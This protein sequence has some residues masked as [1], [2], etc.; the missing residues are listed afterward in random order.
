MPCPAV[1]SPAAAPQCARPGCARP[2]RVR[3]MCRSHYNSTRTKRIRAGDWAPRVSSV[4]ISR[5]LQALM[6]L[7]WP[8]AELG[9]RLGLP[10]SWLSR[11]TTGHRPSVNPATAERVIALY[12]QLSMTPGPSPSARRHATGKGWAPPLAWDDD[13][14]DDP[15]GRA[16]RGRWASVPFVERYRELRDLGLTDLQICQR[17]KVQPGSL[18]RQLHRYGLPVGA[19]LSRAVVT[20]KAARR[21]ARQASA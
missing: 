11:L 6:A 20:D 17:L 12:E 13:T 9:R 19:Q 4:G 15:H 8:Q 1:V 5:R 14:I 21:T 3:G 10:Q 2:A 16:D 7:G 18:A